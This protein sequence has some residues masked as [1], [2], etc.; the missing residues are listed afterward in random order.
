MKIKI[1]NIFK[2]YKLAI[3]IALG[4][5]IVGVISIVVLLNLTNDSSIKE[6]KNN[7]YILKYDDTWKISSKEDKFI[8]LKH[9]KGSTINIEIVELQNEYKYSTIDEIL[10]ELLYDIEEQNKDYKLISKKEGNIT[11]N[12]YNGYKLLYENGDSQAMVVIGKKS[13]KFIIFTYEATNDYFDI[14]LD[15]VHNIIYDFDTVEQSF[16][17]SH[18]LNVETKNIEYFESNAVKELLGKST[19]YEIA[20]N[21]YYVKYS[22]PSGFNAGSIDSTRGY[23][24]FKGLEN[25]SIT[26]S[27]NIYNKNI[28]EYLDKNQ[29]VNVYSGFKMYKT[30]EDYSKF[31]ESVDKFSSEYDSYIYKNSYYYDKAI[32]YDKDFNS[33]NYSRLKENIV[34]MYA[35]DRN[36]LLLVEIKSSEVRIPK[37]LIDMIKIE[38]SENY[39]SFVVSE[40]ENGYIISDLKRKKEYGS[41]EIEQIKL[42][43]PDK[44]KETENGTNIYENRYY[45]LNYNEELEIYDYEV[46]YSLTSKFS[47]LETQIDSINRFFPQSYGDYK[48]LVHSGKKEINGKEFQIYEGGYTE[49]AGIMFTS[50][51]R[52]RY[53]ANVKVLFYELSTGGYLVIKVEGNGVQISD[54][55][56]NDLTDFEI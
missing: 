22:I 28:Y 33:S 21:N 45:K 27:V 35:L 2:K 16:N 18:N 11:K 46:S 52:V 23:F 20:S 50:V 36:H 48:Y 38:S 44:Y 17:L 39:S 1:Q 8:R 56:L 49:L 29:A 51:N 10:D 14:L 31:T 7:N 34:L 12:N 32:T 54:E 37:E 24:D 4:I 25:G 42:K 26:I 43:I 53:Y 41:E 9:N 40:K 15:S 19:Q 30:G 13:D 6:F 5:I 3:F 47:K 55:I